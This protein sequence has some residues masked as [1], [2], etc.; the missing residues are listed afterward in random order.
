M[1][2]E[3]YMLDETEPL[4]FLHRL[5]NA[6]VRK[7]SDGFAITSHSKTQ[8]GLSCKIKKKEFHACIERKIHNS[9]VCI[10]FAPLNK[11]ENDLH[12]EKS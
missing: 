8:A 12:L 11:I 3:V 7:H 5:D 9:F 4:L 1:P 6:A 2:L 10:T